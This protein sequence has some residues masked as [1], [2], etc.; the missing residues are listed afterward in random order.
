MN[1]YNEFNIN[2]ICNFEDFKTFL[3][4][5]DYNWMGLSVPYNIN[6]N[7]EEMYGFSVKKITSLDNTIIV[8]EDASIWGKKVEGNRLNARAVCEKNPYVR[9]IEQ[10]GTTFKV[11]RMARK[12][13]GAGERIDYQ[14]TFNNVEFVLEKDL[15]ADWIKYLAQTKPQYAQ[16][17]LERCEQRKRA[18]MENYDI[19]KQL[20]ADE[21]K[22]LDAQEIELRHSVENRM[23]SYKQLEAII[24]SVKK[25]QEV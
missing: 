9:Y 22:K 5:H 24:K 21:R 12:K 17:M 4:E 1:K 2:N 25:E 16:F 15:S 10:S 11:Y 7:I 19:R 8:L 3:M 23:S 13:F 20:I 18:L 14:Y 6:K